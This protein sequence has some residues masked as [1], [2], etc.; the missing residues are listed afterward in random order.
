MGQVPLD[1]AFVGPAASDGTKL[2]EAVVAAW[3][4]LQSLYKQ[5]DHPKI[6]ATYYDG[7]SARVSASEPLTSFKTFTG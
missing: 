1:I 6:F 5:V 7:A 2:G 3:Q 4:R